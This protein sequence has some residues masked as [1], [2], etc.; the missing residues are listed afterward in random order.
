MHTHTVNTPTHT[1]THTHTPTPTHTYTHTHTHTHT[2]NTHT[3]THNVG[4]NTQAYN[5]IM[6][7][8]Q[9]WKIWALWDRGGTLMVLSEDALNSLSPD[10]HNAHTGP[11]MWVGLSDMCV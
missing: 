8:L 1:H 9:K 2:V 3:Q 4:A 7:C 6:L 10:T 11:C 5:N